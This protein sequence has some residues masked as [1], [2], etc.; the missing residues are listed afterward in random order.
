MKTNQNQNRI[1]PVGEDGLYLEYDPDDT[2]IAII[3]S[4]NTVY[5]ELGS[6]VLNADQIGDLI[7]GLDRIRQSI[8]LR[9]EMRS[10]Q[11]IPDHQE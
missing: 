6:V 9:S 10:G 11:T 7:N 5:D 8:R 4:D 2:W 3:D 1:I